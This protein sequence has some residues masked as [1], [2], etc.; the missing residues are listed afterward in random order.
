MLTGEIRN[1]Y[2]QA[3]K[4]T[5]TSPPKHAGSKAAAPRRRRA[6]PQAISPANSET[7]AKGVMNWGWREGAVDAQ[8][9]HIEVRYGDAAK[10]AYDEWASHRS[11][12]QTDESC[13][14]GIVANDS[15]RRCKK[16]ARLLFGRQARGES[17]GLCQISLQHSC[18]HVFQSA[19]V[20]LHKRNP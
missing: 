7:K 8:E 2:R 18:E 14:S 3:R 5:R 16:G 15:N 20:I 19:L 1:Q 13:L 17:L 6:A 11:D 10:G 9:E 12:R 4:T